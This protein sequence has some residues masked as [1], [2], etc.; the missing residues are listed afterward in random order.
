M[1]TYRTFYLILFIILL[2]ACE[3]RMAPTEYWSKLFRTQTDSSYYQGKSETLANQIAKDVEDYEI[4]KITVM[5]F[6]D[7][8]NRTS[9]LGEY[10]ASRVVE[11]F[12]DRSLFQDRIFHVTQKGE[13]H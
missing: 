12:T 6:V 9:I 4:N 2:S 5:D 7:E 1:K 8:G 13:V 3:L 11:A 10:L